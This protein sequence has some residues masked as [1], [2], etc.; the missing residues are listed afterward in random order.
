[1]GFAAWMLLGSGVFLLYCVYLGVS[2]IAEFKSVIT[3]QTRP[4]RKP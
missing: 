1:M 3:N 4:V 2:P